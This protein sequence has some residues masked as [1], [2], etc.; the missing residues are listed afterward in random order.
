MNA[1]V[2]ECVCFVVGLAQLALLAAVFVVLV[3]LGVAFGVWLVT[4]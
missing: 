3:G 4:P 1:T 2:Y